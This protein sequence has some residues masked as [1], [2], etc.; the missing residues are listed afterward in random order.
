MHNRCNFCD[1]V[2]IYG[3]TKGRKDVVGHC[4][5]EGR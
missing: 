3:N 1:D 5:G 4:G 2:T